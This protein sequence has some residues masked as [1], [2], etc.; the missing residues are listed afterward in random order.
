MR[1]IFFVMFCAVLALAV[2][3]CAISSGIV[4]R[5]RVDIDV[6]GNQGVIYGP[7]PAPH[8]VKESSRDIYALDV[9]LATK[10]E[11]AAA[12]KKNKNPKSNETAAQ[13]AK[14][15]DTGVWGNAGNLGATKAEKIK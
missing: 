5:D 10:D 11:V 9:E 2:S 8:A 1:G 3:G 7:I 14:T 4:Q 12:I 15:T 13:P 6:A